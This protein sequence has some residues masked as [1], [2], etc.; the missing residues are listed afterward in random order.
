MLF[1]P[2]LS[3]SSLSLP[4]AV[5]LRLVSVLFAKTLFAFVFVYS[6]QR[7]SISSTVSILCGHIC[8]RGGMLEIGDGYELGITTDSFI[9]DC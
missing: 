7:H 5:L 9:L 4:Q 6:R 2:D 3:L 8:A 1:H